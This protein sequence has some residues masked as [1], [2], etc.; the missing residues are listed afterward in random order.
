MGDSHAGDE[1]REDD[2]DDPEGSRREVLSESATG[3]DE[4]GCSERGGEER[5]HESGTNLSRWVW[6]EDRG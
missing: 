1:A 5:R 2:V 4:A 6:E 3:G